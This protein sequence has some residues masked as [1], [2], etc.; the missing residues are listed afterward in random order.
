MSDDD[1]PEADILPI[2]HEIKLM[3]HTRAVTALALDPSGSRLITG[4]Y[5]YELKFW[6]FAGMNQTFRPFRSIE[7]C[8]GNQIHDLHYSLT[9][10]SFLVI[11]GT[12]RAK[13]F[14][15]E[16]SELC[17]YVKGDPYIRDLR[18]TD[19]HVA[20]LT[21]GA[22]HPKD[23]QYFATS[24]KDGTIRIWD[25]DRKR[26]QKSVIVHKSRERGG[27]S[28]ATTMTYSLDGKMITGAFMDGTIQIWGADGPY[29][30]P[31]I[32]I[33]N[34]HQK[35]TETSS[36]VFARDGHTLVSRGGDDTVKGS[37]QV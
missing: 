25:V 15:R 29:I 2:S 28:A 33:D 6:D 11:S 12:A 5:D 13:L 35:L 18:H 24:S 9:G 4:G 30:R 16:G 22:W 1:E 26:K 14:D 32:S 20:A 36:L 23:R 27:R 3:D 21:S 8:E 7:P 10:D 34:A 19:G 17:E 31:S 37:K